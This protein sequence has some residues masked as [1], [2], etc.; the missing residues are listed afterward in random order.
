MSNL[1]ELNS[2]YKTYPDEPL[3]IKESL[4]SFYKKKEK[5]FHKPS[6]DN[7][8]FSVQKGQS[9]GLVGHNGAGKSTLLALIFGALK[10][11]KGS[12][13]VRGKVIPLLTLGSGFHPELTGKENIFLFSSIQGI[14]ISETKEKYDSICE[15]S[16]LGDAINKP[17]RSYSSG[18]M[19]RL[20]FS[21]ATSLPGD[22]ILIDEILGV[23]DFNFQKKCRRFLQEFR[24]NNGTF[25]F[26]NFFYLKKL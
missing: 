11:D 17:I 20:G 25:I 15:F 2:I 13:E 21:V 26:I 23:G 1:I 4:V 6:L 8:S 14:S 19:A 3:G 22:I 18:M 24:Q 9:F 7:I 5:A 12:I 16:E 10:P